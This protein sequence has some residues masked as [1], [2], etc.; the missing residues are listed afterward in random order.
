MQFPVDSY[1]LKARYAPG[2]LLSL[3]VLL[4]FWTCFNTEIKEVSGVI[5]TLLSGVLVYA[6]SAIVRG[7]GKR[8]EPKLIK[9][10]GGLPSTL[11]V[12]PNDITLGQELKRQ[13]I[14]LAGKYF[15]LPIPSAEEQVSDPQK[16]AQL[17][18]QLFSKIK[19]I[20]RKHDKNGLWFIADA[21]Y[22]FARNLYG[23]RRAW[24]I[25]SVIATIASA[26][27]LYLGFAKLV[28]VGFIL[29]ILVLASCI[30]LGWFIL[31]RL[32]R[33]IGFR[34]AEHAWESFYNIVLEKTEK[35]RGKNGRP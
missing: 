7:F 20:I 10:W 11:I 6:L 30:A 5:G 21:E 14:E 13:Y 24:L 9:Q 27:C 18:D 34:Y 8:L 16:S 17:I 12:S 29:D 22:G 23:S 3:P 33:E 1:D 32:T 35:K 2:L 19:G 31:P 25:L 26:F 4:T 15:Q 28:L